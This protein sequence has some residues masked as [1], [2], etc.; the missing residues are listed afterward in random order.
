MLK[1]L[2]LEHNLFFI[3][4]YLYSKVIRLQNDEVIYV[5]KAL[6]INPLGEGHVNPSI[7]LVRELVN[8]GEEIIYYAN[9]MYKDKIETTGAEF[10]PISEKA[11]TLMREFFSQANDMMKNTGNMMGLLAKRMPKMF[12][13]MEWVTDD[14]LKEIESE[15]YDY[16][17]Y[18]ANSLPGKWISEMKK[19]PS[20]SIWTIFVSNRDSNFFEKIMKQR[21]SEFLKAMEEMKEEMEE[22]K[23]RL[24]QKYSISIPDLRQAMLCEADLNIVFTSRYFQP[25]SDRFGDNYLFVGPSIADRKDQGDF[26]LDEL[27]DGPVVYMA[28]GTIVNN[29]PDLYK[30]CIEA[31]QDLDAR[32]VLSIG[33]QLSAS[34]LGPIPDNFI[35]RNYVPQLDVLRH[36]DA[37]I[38]HCGMNS[39]NE[40]LY[41]GVPLV[42]LPLVNDQPFVASRAKELG[43]G[44]VLDH[45]TLDAEKLRNAVEEV[46][47]N[48]VYKRN[49]QK[50][51]KSFREAGGYMKAVDE[52]LKWVN[53]HLISH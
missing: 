31:L 44:V 50:I 2:I 35:V 18:D 27:K 25:D 53:S 1:D 28:L 43:A 17:I 14:I 12:E 34:D 38:T 37:F 16:I 46:L 42:M 47:K 8:R 3:P 22:R 41:F 23:S 10:R 5:S 30:I 9:S 15:T 33:K 36:S 51:S 26:P 24:E 21:G 32:V 39:T 20:V 13:M 11:E 52:L 45:Q 4:Q 40:G 48:P 7:G 29:R 49:S 6:F 19:L